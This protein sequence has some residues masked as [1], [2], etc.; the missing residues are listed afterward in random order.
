MFIV[1]NRNTSLVHLPCYCN[2]DVANFPT[3]SKTD[4][5]LVGFFLQSAD[6]TQVKEKSF[7]HEIDDHHHF[8]DRKTTS[9]GK[10]ESTFL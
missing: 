4:D 7:Q 10:F 5:L 9:D 1:S 2:S 8:D 3:G 6:T